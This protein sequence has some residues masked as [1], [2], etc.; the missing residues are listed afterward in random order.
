MYN[1]KYNVFPKYCWSRSMSC[2]VEIQSAGHFPTT[3][4]V[5]LPD[6]KIVEVERSDLEPK[7]I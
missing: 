4:M 5:I 7:P 6:D 2:V 3:L 1:S